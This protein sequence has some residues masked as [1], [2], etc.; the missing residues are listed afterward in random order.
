[1]Y[2]LTQAYQLNSAT[3]IDESEKG[4]LAEETVEKTVQLLKPFIAEGI[5][6]PQQIFIQLVGGPCASYIIRCKELPPEKKAKFFNAIEK[7]FSLEE[8]RVD[9]F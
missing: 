4:A 3:D 7:V 9:N 2:E 1:V 5:K 8:V 6:A